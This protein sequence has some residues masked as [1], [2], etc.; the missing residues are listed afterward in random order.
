MYSAAGVGVLVCVWRGAMVQAGRGLIRVQAG[1][2]FGRGPRRGGGGCSAPLRCAP[3]DELEFDFN[4]SSAHE[5]EFDF[6]RLSAHE[7]TRARV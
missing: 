1:G 5:L 7:C 4:F 3:A 6:I 2:G